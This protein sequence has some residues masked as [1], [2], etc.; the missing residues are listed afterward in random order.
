MSQL[1]ER[2][3]NISQRKFIRI[4]QRRCQSI[5]TQTFVIIK[6]VNSNCNGKYYTDDAL[7]VSS[8]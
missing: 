6:K 1:V 5:V 7:K 4:M 8:T 2:L 3:Q